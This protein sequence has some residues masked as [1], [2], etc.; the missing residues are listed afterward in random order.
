LQ[1]FENLLSIAEQFEE[2]FCS[3]GVHPHEVEHAGVANSE[4]L[5]AYVKHPKVIGIG[6]TG[7]DYYY[8]N[9]PISAQKANFVSHISAARK[10]GLPLIVHSRDA[11]NDMASIL[12]QEYKKGNFSC[13]LHCFTGG[14][15]LA[16]RALAL[17]CYF[18]FSGIITFK[19]ANNLREIANTIPNDRL[20]VETDSPYLAPVPH[21]GKRNEPAYVCCCN[22][23]LAKIKNVKPE[24]MAE[25]TSKNFCDLFSK[26]P[27]VAI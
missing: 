16:K 22:A 8:K 9:A 17:G 25:L 24:E 18:S 3:V 14:P 19:N 13:V 1:K 21:R 12:E 6:E 20:L 27:E 7:L 4:T 2:V 5:L 11:D 26:M 10:S 23:M 15:G